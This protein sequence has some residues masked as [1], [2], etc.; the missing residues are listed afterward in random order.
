[1]VAPACHQAQ[2]E[3][4]QFVLTRKTCHPASFQSAPLRVSFNLDGRS[5]DFAGQSL[6]DLPDP[7]EVSGIF[8]V[9]HRLQLRGQSR[10][11]RL[12][13][14]PHRVPF[15]SRDLGSGG[16]HQRY[17]N[18]ACGSL[19]SIVDLPALKHA[20]KRVLSGLRDMCGPGRSTGGVTSTESPHITGA[21]WAVSSTAMIIS[22]TSSGSSM[23]G[24]GVGDIHQHDLKD[25]ATGFGPRLLLLAIVANDRRQPKAVV[26]VLHPGREAV[27]CCD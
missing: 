17:R 5:P 2:N 8:D 23:D 14:T 11:W 15:S 22:S 1:M 27:F 4:A 20:V 6:V 7:F 25:L 3:G 24:A 16:N 10:N 21:R 19:S 26:T 13:A 9:A 18:P 12:M